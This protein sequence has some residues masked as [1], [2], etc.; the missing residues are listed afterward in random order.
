MPVLVDALVHV[1]KAGP[2]GEL[3]R[4][5]H[6][7]VGQRQIVH[8]TA[9]IRHIGVDLSAVVDQAGV[10]LAG[11]RACAI[12]DLADRLA[13]H[14][15]TYHT[16]VYPG[17]LGRKSTGHLRNAELV[18]D[19]QV[20]HRRQVQLGSEGVRDRVDAVVRHRAKLC[21]WCC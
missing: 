17:E 19:R 3:V 13:V 12:H 18:I 16:V 8:H 1:E 6:P 10:G 2:E 5:Q 20:T 14:G 4:T 9:H 15:G 11:E 7:L 21:P